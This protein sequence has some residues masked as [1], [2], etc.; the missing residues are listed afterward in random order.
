[1]HFEVDSTVL[2]MLEPRDLPA[3]YGYRND[4]E[5]ATLLGGYS[6]GYTAAELSSW[7]EFHRGRKDEVLWC[8]ADKASDRCLGHV[9]LYRIDHRV[10]SAEFAIL[11]GDRGSW[12]KGLGTKLTAFAVQYGFDWLNLNRVELS[13]LDLN[14]RATAM[15][16]K[17]GFQDEGR[18]RQAQFKDGK[19]IDVL[20]MSVL[21]DEWTPLG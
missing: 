9:G 14:P 4:P 6:R 16:R 20:L 8:I 2:R 19:Y 21:R 5:L 3:L 13:A 10:R 12:G 18:L 7:L 15:Y 11:L 1:M 17:L